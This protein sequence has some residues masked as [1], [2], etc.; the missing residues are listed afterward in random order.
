MENGER[1]VDSSW[2]IVMTGTKLI[3]KN[4]TTMDKPLTIIGMMSGTSVDA[5]DACRDAFV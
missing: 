5:I 1:I 2:L 4:T 3:L